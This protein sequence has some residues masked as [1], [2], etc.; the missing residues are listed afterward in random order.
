MET[1]RARC[2]RVVG[3]AVAALVAVLSCIGAAPAPVEASAPRSDRQPA[4]QPAKQPDTTLDDHPSGRDR[5]G[6]AT[7]ASRSDPDGLKNGG[8]DKPGG[9]GGFDRDKDGN[10]GCG[11]D[12]DFEDDNEGRCGRRR[13]STTPMQ[14]ATGPVTPTVVAAG[15]VS[16]SPPRASGAEVPARLR[17]VVPG[18]VPADV[19]AD[20]L[21]SPSVAFATTGIESDTITALAIALA[22]LGLVFVL[23]TRRS[24]RAPAP[25]PVPAPAPAPAP[26]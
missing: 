21:P 10:N 18:P 24:R 16:S 17:F 22:A 14:T 5:T 13:F 7:G 4:K 2:R 25:A 26:A 6:R 20:P 15:L 23:A 12:D 19:V 8:P 9:S 3:I 1:P 11:N